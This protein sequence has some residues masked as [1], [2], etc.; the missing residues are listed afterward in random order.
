MPGQIA[1]GGREPAQER[2]GGGAPA[3]G[4]GPRRREGGPRQ[5]PPACAVCLQESERLRLAAFRIYEGI[6]A[7]VKR[8]FLAFPLKHH[9]LNL[10]VLLVLHLEDRNADVAQVRGRARGRRAVGSGPRAGAS[11]T[12]LG[13]PALRPLPA[14]LPQPTLGLS[15]SVPQVCRLTL[16]H[17][18]TALGW[19]GLKATFAKKDMWMILRA[20]VRRSPSPGPGRCPPP[21][22]LPAAPGP[23]SPRASSRSWSRRPARPSGFCGSAR[24]S[25]RAPRPPSATRPCGSR[26]R[27]SPSSEP[28]WPCPGD[29]DMRA[30]R[31]GEDCVQLLPPPLQEAPGGWAALPRQDGLQSSR[32]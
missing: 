28:L 30:R 17:M 20:L 3:A 32:G 21:A 15:R 2:G 5:R 25:S 7:K 27:R 4:A 14:L 18:A 24:P 19:S 23:A 22:R 10:I 6:L 8:G 29:W 26:V 16:C 13:V 12:R 1:C 31:A 9:V 11:P